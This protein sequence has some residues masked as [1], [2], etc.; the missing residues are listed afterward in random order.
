MPMSEKTLYVCMYFIEMLIYNVTW[1]SGVQQSDSVL[2]S[3]NI[4]QTSNLS[5]PAPPPVFW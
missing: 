4:C 3:V 1:V 2:N 5:L